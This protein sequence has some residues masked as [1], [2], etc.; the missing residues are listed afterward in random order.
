MYIISCLIRYLRAHLILWLSA[1]HAILLICLSFHWLNQSLTYGDELLLIQLSSGVRYFLLDDEEKPDK[2]DF[3]FVNTAYDRTLAD[4]YDS[5]L[6][7]F[8][9]LFPPDCLMI[10]N[11]HNISVLST[12]IFNQSISGRAPQFVFR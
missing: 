4:K 7:L 8:S 2:K 9:C 6:L 1:V 11:Y 5:N 12:E 3:L 10:G